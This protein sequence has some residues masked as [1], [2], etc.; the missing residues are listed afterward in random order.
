MLCVTDKNLLETQ[1]AQYGRRNSE[2][3]CHIVD[4]YIAE[5]AA[6]DTIVRRL[7]NQASARGRVYVWCA[8]ARARI[9]MLA[10]LL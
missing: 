1:R 6:A 9:R 3:W 2:W 7:V 4:R 8:N 5:T 10:A